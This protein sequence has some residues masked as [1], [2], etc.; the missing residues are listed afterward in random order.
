MRQRGKG[1][2]VVTAAACLLA[3][4]TPLVAQEVLT[5]RQAVDLALRSNPL[6]TAT[7]AGEKEAEARIRE[8]RSRYMPHAQF[9][10]SVQRGNNP[11]FVF[12][13]LL[14]QHQ[15][16]EDRFAVDSLNRPAALSNYQSRLTVEQVLFDAR[17]TSRGVQ[18]AR[19][20]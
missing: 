16:S 11:V 12:T 7:D 14:T 17:Q 4:M 18:V 1:A 15:F 19:F 5:L 8:A 13:S 20:T 3:L 6:V 9:S 2:H 10:E